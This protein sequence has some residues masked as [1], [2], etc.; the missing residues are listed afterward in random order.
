MQHLWRTII[1]ADPAGR[2]LRRGQRLALRCLVDGTTIADRVL[3]DQV[4]SDGE[5]IGRSRWLGISIGFID[6][7]NQ[8]LV[9]RHEAEARRMLGEI[10]DLRELCAGANSLKPLQWLEIALQR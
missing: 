6:L 2:F 10:E 8:L 9:T 4:F 5:A 1:Y 3:L 7:L